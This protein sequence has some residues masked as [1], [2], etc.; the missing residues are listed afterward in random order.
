M[1]IRGDEAG[2]WPAT[3]IDNTFPR[4]LP[5]ADMNNAFG[6]SIPGTT[7]MSKVQSPLNAGWD[8]AARHPYHP[9]KN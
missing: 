5:R 4:A 3:H 1:V 6:V 7:K 9:L 8:G 2:L